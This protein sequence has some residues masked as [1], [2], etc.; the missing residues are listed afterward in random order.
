[1]HIPVHATNARASCAR[2]CGLSVRPAPRQTG[3]QERKRDQ[4]RNSQQIGSFP[5]CLHEAEGRSAM[6][7]ATNPW[8][9]MTSR[10]KAALDLRS[11]RVA[12]AAAAMPV[13]VGATERAD[14]AVGTRMCRQR[15]TGRGRGLFGAPKSAMP[16][17]CFLLVTFLCTSK[18]KSP[19][20]RRRVEASFFRNPSAAG[21]RVE[22]LLRARRLT[23]RPSKGE[24]KISAS[25][26]QPTQPVRAQQ[27][28]GSKARRRR[29]V[30]GGDLHARLFG[31]RRVARH[32]ARLDERLLVACAERADLGA[33][34]IRPA[35]G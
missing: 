11:L 35:R 27:R 6:P 8:H 26:K 21:R 30:A 7:R 33:E 9:L 22:A 29:Y 1:M 10:K 16:R 28:C 17:V 13:R 32:V 24:R 20:R 5:P 25:K 18:E 15:N 34:F 2:P 3:S 12:A 31:A 4:K 23:L 19:A 14:S